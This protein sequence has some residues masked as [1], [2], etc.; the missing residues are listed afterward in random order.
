MD[1]NIFLSKQAC[2]YKLSIIFRYFFFTFPTFLYHKFFF[3]LPKINFVGKFFSN[4]GVVATKKNAHILSEADK[5]K[6]APLSLPTLQ[7]FSAR[8]KICALF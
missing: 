5:K 2:E 6:E 3:E 8:R 1:E 7:I 4:L